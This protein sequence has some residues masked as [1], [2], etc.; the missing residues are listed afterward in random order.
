AILE[1]DPA[2]G[3]SDGAP[4]PAPPRSPV[5]TG[6]VT[7]LF[8]DIEGS[9]RL[10]RQLGDGY[11]ALLEQHHAVLRQTL[12]DQGEEID[13]Q[14]DAFFFA[15]RRSRD[16]V[17][18]A[19]EAQRALAE[20]HWP[21]EVAVR[22][23]IGIHTG[24]PGFAETGYHGMDVVRAARI[25][26]S[27]HGG[28][29][30]VSSA[31]R[32][33]RG[34]HVEGVSLPHL[35]EHRLKDIELPQRQFQVLAP[36]LTEDFPPPRTEDAARVMTIGGRERELA[37]AAEAALGAE[38]RRV[39]LFRRSRLVAVLGVLVLAGVI[40]GLAV[41]LTSGSSGAVG[42]GAVWI[43]RGNRV[44]RIDPTTSQVTR[45]ISVEPPLGLTVG[46][47]SVWVTTRIDHVL[48]IEPRSAA[49]TN[50]FSLPTA[51]I[52]PTIGGGFLWIILTGL[53]ASGNVWALNPDT[54]DAAAT[55]SGGDFPTDLAWGDRLVWSA[56]SRAIVRIGN[57]ASLVAR[58][59][60]T[61]Q[62]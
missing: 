43:T 33:V 4:E 6:T 31:T 58:I 40:A 25:S 35:G 48:R 34:D 27:A 3:V 44:L 26:G 10:V 28:Q 19:V 32:D 49:I 22:I 18:A 39:R 20:A 62:P 21:M 11:G 52:A 42:A 37:A 12:G 50:T 13:N 47:G 56:R 8:T 15:F 23:R 53:P 36:G 7:F 9:T 24:E 59:P 55:T 54:G 30:L 5:P 38:E 51:A 1:H 45:S 29:I 17:R 61:A 14:G 16:A 57:E 46:A 2:L 60:I 41:V